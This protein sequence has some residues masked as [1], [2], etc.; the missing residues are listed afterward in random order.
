MLPLS[1]HEQLKHRF[2]DKLSARNLFVH[3]LK[4]SVKFTIMKE[5]YLSNFALIFLFTNFLYKS[6]VCVCCICLCAPYT[7]SPR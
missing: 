7:R 6:H 4:D 1:S 2:K 3:L 5:Q